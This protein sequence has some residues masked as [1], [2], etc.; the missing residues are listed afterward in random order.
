MASGALRIDIRTDRN[1][2]VFEHDGARLEPDDLK[3]LLPRA[4]GKDDTPLRDLAIGVNAAL[5]VADGPVTVETGQGWQMK[6]GADSESL[7]TLPVSHE[8]ACVRLSRPLGFWARVDLLIG[9]PEYRALS[10]LCRFA[11]IPVFV[12]GQLVQKQLS[13]QPQGPD[14]KN[15]I[16]FYEPSWRWWKLEG[17]TPNTRRFS[18]PRDH[19]VVELRLPGQ[20]VGLLP[21]MASLLMRSAEGPA[22]LPP[23]M[24]QPALRTLFERRTRPPMPVMEQA[25]VFLGV[26]ALP[27]EIPDEARNPTLE[28]QKFLELLQVQLPHPPGVAL[29]HR[30][31][32]VG[33]LPAQYLVGAWAVTHQGFDLTSLKLRERDQ[34]HLESEVQAMSTRLFTT[35]NE[36]YPGPNLRAT[37]QAAWL[38]A[39]TRRSGESGRI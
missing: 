15:V 23:E 30:G 4:L 13:A 16:S 6:F 22:E 28:M 9:T 7:E 37:L 20:G 3:N 34:S 10:T 31:V 27:A 19:N 17:F 36:L 14:Q 18:V 8:R 5:R 24:P 12:N 21:S 11:P 38:D 25:G 33:Y 35:L 32:T 29:V 2:T 39:H 26:P 1:G